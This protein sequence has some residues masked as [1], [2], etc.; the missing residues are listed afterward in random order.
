MRTVAD[1]FYERSRHREV[2]PEEIFGPASGYARG[3]RLAITGRDG[4]MMWECH[5]R[6]RRY[7]KRV[8]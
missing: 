4:A 7:W 6:W 8:R 3:T 1:I 2:R 5:G